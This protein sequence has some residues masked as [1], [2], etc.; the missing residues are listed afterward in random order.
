MLVG[1]D[2]GTDEPDASGPFVTKAAEGTERSAPVFTPSSFQQVVKSVGQVFN[3]LFLLAANGGLIAQ[4]PAMEVVNPSSASSLT[5]REREIL[6]MVGIGL[7]NQAIAN[8][9]FISDKTVKTHVTSILSKLKMVNRTEL[10]LFA[11]QTA[12][13]STDCKY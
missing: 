5:K 1:T 6:S 7:S 2:S 13:K 11:V 3:L 4:A 10:A 9:L 8:R 12:T